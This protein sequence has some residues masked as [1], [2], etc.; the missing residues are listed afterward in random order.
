[1]NQQKKKVDPRE[2]GT[3][4]YLGFDDWRW[5]FPCAAAVGIPLILQDV[6]YID[7][8][9]YLIGAF[10][11][12]WHAYDAI[13]FPIWN[14]KTSW[15]GESIKDSWVQFDN[16]AV[17]EINSDIKINEEFLQTK[18]VFQDIFTGVDEITAAQA[19]AFN[20]SNKND[21]H[22][23][24]QKKLDA[25]VSLNEATTVAI[26]NDMIATVREEAQKTLLNDKK[27]KDAALAQAIA[28]LAAGPNGTRGKDVVGEVYVKSISDYR[29]GLSNKQHKVHQITAKLEA[30]IAEIVKAPE[31]IQSAGNVFETNPILGN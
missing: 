3:L 28:T 31:V 9:L 7:Y 26:R 19:T 5:A 29:A 21:F 8:K 6:I 25:L 27:V 1:L 10:S 17:K 20:L 12:M 14:E 11:L 18:E 13:L 4:Q 30:E 2:V 15:L 16:D 24:I 22:R 23:A